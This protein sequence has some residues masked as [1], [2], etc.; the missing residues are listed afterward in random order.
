MAHEH[1]EQCETLQKAL[2]DARASQTPPM[3]EAT[4][5]GMQAAH[6]VDDTDV[7]PN[8]SPDLEHD[9]SNI[10]QELRDMG[11]EPR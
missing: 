9:I 7:T 6:P 11:C 10:E 1:N 8:A 4:I 2:A 5:V 3:R